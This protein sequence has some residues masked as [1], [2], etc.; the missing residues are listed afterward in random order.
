MKVFLALA[1]VETFL[2]LIVCVHGKVIVQVELVVTLIT[3]K[4]FSLAWVDKVAIKLVLHCH[5]S[6][7]NGFCSCCVPT[8]TEFTPEV[9]HFLTLVCVLNVFGGRCGR[10]VSGVTVV[11]RRLVD[12]IL[13]H[14]NFLL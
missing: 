13:H 4:P 1:T 14:V 8:P 9:F 2:V 5:V 7:E 6:L 11:T 10:G 3:F 12:L